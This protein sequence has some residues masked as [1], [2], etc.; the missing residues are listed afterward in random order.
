MDERKYQRK[1]RIIPRFPVQANGWRV[2]QGYSA[3][4][5]ESQQA[6]RCRKGSKSSREESNCSYHS[7]STLYM[8]LAWTG[9]KRIVLLFCLFFKVGLLW[10]SEWIGKFNFLLCSLGSLFSETKSS[11]SESV[12]YFLHPLCL[13]VILNTCTGG[14]VWISGLN[15]V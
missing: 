15:E 4:A 10:S 14:D 12:R 3:Q 9:I 11:Y 1:S 5:V 6:R 7:T 8:M 2:D 13:Q